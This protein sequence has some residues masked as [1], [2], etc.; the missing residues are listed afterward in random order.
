MTDPQPPTPKP[1]PEARQCVDE[2]AENFGA[3]AVYSDLLGRWGVMTPRNGGHWAQ[4]DEVADWA[5]VKPV[6]TADPAA[7]G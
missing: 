6:E 4:A 1:L 5:P 3:V 2:A 7:T